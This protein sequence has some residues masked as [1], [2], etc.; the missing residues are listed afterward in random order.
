MSVILYRAGDTHTIK[1]VP[2]D[3]VK[4]RPHSLRSTLDSDKGWVL[5]VDELYPAVLSNSEIRDLAKEKG[6]R[7]HKTA[8]IDTLKRFLDDDS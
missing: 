5:S 8:R 7:L 4:V 2:C 3:I 1:G 6:H